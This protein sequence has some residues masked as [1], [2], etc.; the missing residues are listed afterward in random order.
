MRVF[1]HVHDVST[2]YARPCRP[3]HRLD[4]PTKISHLSG[5]ARRN[6]QVPSSHHR[7]GRRQFGTG[8]NGFE[9]SP[10]SQSARGAPEG[11]A[12]R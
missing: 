1:H 8:P 7:F 3:V 9:E 2:R 12:D 6:S 5:M 11:S 10:W 4:V